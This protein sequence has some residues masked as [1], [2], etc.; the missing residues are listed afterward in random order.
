LQPLV[1]RIRTLD[2]ELKKRRQGSGATSEDAVPT[3]EAGPPPG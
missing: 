2:A 1:D 3:G